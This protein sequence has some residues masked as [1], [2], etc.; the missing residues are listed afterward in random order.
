MKPDPYDVCECGDYR[1]DHKGG[2]G[3]C[4]FNAPDGGHGGAPKCNRFRFVE[5]GRN[6]VSGE[7]IRRE[8]TKTG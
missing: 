4:F 8:P 2:K 7:L 3:E 6:W 5:R 1:G